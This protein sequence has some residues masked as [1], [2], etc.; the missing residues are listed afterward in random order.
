MQID[1]GVKTVGD[2]LSIVTVVGTLAQALPAI[3]ALFT[4]I[5]TVLR[6]YETDTVQGLLGKKK[7]EKK[8]E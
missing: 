8:E 4:I 2:A 3:A 1:E 7:I 5:W 6:I